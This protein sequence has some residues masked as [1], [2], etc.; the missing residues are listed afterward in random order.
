MS[1]MKIASWN[2]NSIRVRL[3][4]VKEWLQTVKPDVLVL[5]ETKVQDH[6]FPVDDFSA[7]GYQ[8]CFI[9][10]KS[11]NG[12]AILYH[13]GLDPSD[14]ATQMPDYKDEE[15]RFLAATFAGIHVVNVYVP[16]GRHIDHEAYQ[17]KMEWLSHLHDYLK[18]QLAKH[19]RL[20]VLG[21]FNI[22]PKDIDVHDPQAWE[23][24]VLVSP[25]ERDALEGLLD[26][27]LHDSFRALNDKQQLFSWWPY[28]GFAFRRQRGLRIDLALVS[29]ALLSSC[30]GSDIDVTPRQ[31]DRPSDHAP[32][33]IDCHLDS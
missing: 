3:D 23:G 19:D 6:D 5:Q 11:Y 13:K 14:I 10:Q 22:A 2:V 1:K 12:V 18:K 30:K 16:N 21:D 15:K 8:V 24:D 27:G 17:Y 33:F 29:D 4:H 31:W 26:L 20:V 25:R 32:I 9:G 28:K 7:L